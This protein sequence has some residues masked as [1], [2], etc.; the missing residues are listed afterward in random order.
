M[1]PTLVTL[2][3]STSAARRS[4]FRE[5]PHETSDAVAPGP[6]AESDVEPADADEDSDPIAQSAPVPTHAHTPHPGPDVHPAPMSPADAVEQ[7]I[8]ALRAAIG[9]E[10][11]DVRLKVGSVH[12]QTGH[13]LEKFLVERKL[14]VAAN[15]VEQS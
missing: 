9:D 4:T 6:D 12:F 3:C 2:G 13:D 15:E 7:V 11:A 8:G 5:A 1:P 14:E 10:K